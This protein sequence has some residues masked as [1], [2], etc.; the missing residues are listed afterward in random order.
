[1]IH[2]SQLQFGYFEGGFRLEVD[3]LQVAAGER[4][5]FTGPSGIGKT[6]LLELV[7]GILQPAQGIVQCCGAELSAMS[8]SARR[9]FRIA[10][11][12]LVFQDFALLDYL[13]VLANILLPFRI[14][15]SLPLDSTTVERAQRLA[16]EMGLAELLRR[17]PAQLSAGQQQRTAVCRALVTNPQVVLADEP[18]T[19]LDP[20]SG[21]RVMDVLSRHTEEHDAALVIVSHDPQVIDRLERRVDISRFASGLEVFGAGEGSGAR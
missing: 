6:T 5:G 21:R 1:M 16:G 20:A 17:R 7:A 9:D 18:T 8:D 19:N 4:V 13:S 15:R 2:V 10:N 3:Q 14:N 11:V 12:G